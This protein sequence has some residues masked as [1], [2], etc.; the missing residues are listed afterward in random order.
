MKP[1]TIYL[2]R[3][4]SD[5]VLDDDDYEKEGSGELSWDLW[6]GVKAM[7]TEEENGQIARKFRA[8]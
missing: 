1:S 5:V 8:L 6:F 3:C 4:F 7:Q 2:P